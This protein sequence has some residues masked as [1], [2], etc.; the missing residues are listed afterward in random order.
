MRSLPG[1]GRAEMTIQSPLRT[2]RNGCRCA[3]KRV[4]A[5]MGSPW[6]PA[7]RSRSFDAGTVST[8]ASGMATPSGT[9]RKPSSRAVLKFCCRLR[10][11]TATRR[12]NCAAIRTRCWMRW[13]FEAKLATTMRPGASV[14]M[15]SN[16]SWRSRSEPDRD[17]VAHSH[18]LDAEGD[19]LHGVP[20]SNLAQVRLAQDAMLPKLR[21]D[22][23]QRQPRAEHGNVQLLQ[24]KRQATDVVLM[25]VGEENPEDLAPAVEQIRDVGQ[26]Q[27]DAEHVLLR[28][29]QPGVHDQD[30]VLPL[31]RPHVDAD[32]AETAQRKVPETRGQRSRS[33]SD[34]CFAGAAATGGGGGLSS[35]SRYRLRASKSRSRSATSEPLCSAAAGW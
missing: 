24:R 8:S 13:M 10:P 23:S 32:L 33:C 7:V 20:H 35:W 3:A 29:H 2:L 12:P 5:D 14:K 11:T 17:R 15:R 30:S 28:E 19:Q 27:V 22:E 26:D 16:G 18:R 6:L 21:L 25:P 34:S 4:S 1:I 31:E 9:L